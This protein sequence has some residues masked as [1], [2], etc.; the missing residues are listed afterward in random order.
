VSDREHELIL[1]FGFLHGV[2]F[3][4]ARPEKTDDGYKQAG[5]SYQDFE[6]NWYIN[7]SLGGCVRAVWLEHPVR[8]LGWPI[9]VDHPG[10][11]DYPEKCFMVHD[12]SRIWT[13]SNQRFLQGYI[14]VDHVLSYCC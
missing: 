12:L 5:M 1:P 10:A 13:I 7:K 14:H 11:Y 4:D 9:S 6:W 8:V 2:A 3:Y